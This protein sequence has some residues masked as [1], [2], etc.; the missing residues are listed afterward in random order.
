MSMPARRGVFAIRRFRLAD[1]DRLLEIERG[2]FPKSPYSHDFFLELYAECGDLFLVAIAGC[3]IAGYIVTCTRPPR[4]ELVSIAVDRRWRRV[5]IAQALI[6]HT[7]ARLRRARVATLSLMVR[8]ANR[9]AIAL[10]HE[11][12]FRRVRRVPRYYENGEDGVRMMLRLTPASG[13]PPE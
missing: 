3:S 11:L 5:G 13:K 10:Y 2:A 7:L 8:A 6:R 4:A 1:L 9:G 12:G